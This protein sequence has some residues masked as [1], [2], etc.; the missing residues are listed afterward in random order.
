MTHSPRTPPSLYD[1]LAAECRAM[2]AMLWAGYT[3]AEAEEALR[4]SLDGPYPP[5]SLAGQSERGTSP[6]EPSPDE[7]GSSESTSRAW[8]S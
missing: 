2:L 5:P 3:R 8:T 1:R 4:A 6:T 7:A